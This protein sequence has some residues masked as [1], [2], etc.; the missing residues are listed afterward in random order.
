LAKELSKS[1]KAAVKTAVGIKVVADEHK[2]ASE[3]AFMKCLQGCQ[4][5]GTAE[6]KCQ[7][8]CQEAMSSDNSSELKDDPSDSL[9]DDKPDKKATKADKKAAKAAKQL[10]V[11][12]TKS[13]GML[14]KMDGCNVKGNKCNLKQIVKQIQS[15]MKRILTR[16]NK[17]DSFYQSKLSRD[18]KKLHAHVRDIS[19]DDKRKLEDAEKK[20]LII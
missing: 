2:I 16:F 12:I 10:A 3:I 8:L 13:W 1:E 4:K 20:V 17:L 11:M 7:D 18:V 14:E 19:F 9:D 6:E 15:M 5:E